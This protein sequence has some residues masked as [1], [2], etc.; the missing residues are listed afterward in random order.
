MAI[1]PLSASVPAAPIVDSDG[2]VTTVWRGF[3]LALQARTGGAPGAS[4]GTINTGLTTETA[5]RIA[6]DAALG[7]A[8]SNEAAAR[9]TA[10]AAEQLARINADTD[11]AHGISENTTAIAANPGVL[12]ESGTA[13]LKISRLPAFNASMPALGTELVPIVEG[14]ATTAIQL[15]QLY[16][17]S[18]QWLDLVATNP[19]DAIGGSGAAGREVYLQAGNG[20]GVGAGGGSFVYGGAGGATGVGGEVQLLGGSGGSASGDGGAVVVQGGDSRSTGG[21]ITILAGAGD[22]DGGGINV[23]TGEGAGISGTVWVQSGPLYPAINAGNT[24]DAFIFSGEAAGNSGAAGVGT[25]G[26]NGTSGDVNMS[27]GTSATGASG[28]ILMLTGNANGADAG[29]L[30]YI[31]GLVASGNGAGGSLIFSGGQGSGTGAGG[32]MQ[33][34]AGDSGTGATGNGGAVD[35]VSGASHATNGNGGDIT[36]TTGAGNGTGHRGLVVLNGLPTAAPATSGA[37]WRDAGAGNVIKC[38]P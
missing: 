25:G 9:A 15:G 30:Y 26:A 12:L 35:L 20:D 1:N 4:T 29:G 8:I 7:T 22:T 27:T 36:L 17:Y 2:N 5:N 23:L 28:N 6:A 33:F 24:G 13:G 16:R 38:V 21:A 10:I 37:I 14:G 11:F 3:F 31:G 32:R 34:G 18:V 19:L